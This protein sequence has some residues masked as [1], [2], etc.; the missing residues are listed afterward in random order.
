MLV[1]LGLLLVLASAILIEF[2]LIN[3]VQ[4]GGKAFL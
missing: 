2:K 3:Q 1:S 4:N